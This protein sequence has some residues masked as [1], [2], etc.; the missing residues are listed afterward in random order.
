MAKSNASAKSAQ[1]TK[2]VRPEADVTRRARDDAEA[3]VA[4]NL[5][6]KTAKKGK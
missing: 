6:R 2:R 4:A 3:F 1:S 5:K